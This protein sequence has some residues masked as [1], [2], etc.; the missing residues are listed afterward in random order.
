[1]RLCSHPFPPSPSQLCAERTLTPSPWVGIPM[2][3]TSKRL[4]GG[5]GEPEPFS[6]SLCFLWHLCQ[7]L[8]PFWSPAPTELSNSENWP[9]S[10]RPSS[11][12]SQLCPI[13]AQRMGGASFVASLFPVWFTALPSLCKQF[14]K[15]NPLCLKDLQ[16]FLFP[17]RPE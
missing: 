16:H 17:G 7:Q 13:P 15:L 8:H 5:G 12:P 14:P 6:L 9:L 3:T 2:R 11:T 4:K 1:M 10:S